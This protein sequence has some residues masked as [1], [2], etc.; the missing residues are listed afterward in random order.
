M[1][2]VSARVP[3]DVESELEA[4]M[5][6]ENVDRSTAIRKLIIEGL[7]DWR[8]ER[9]LDALDAGEV[10]LSRAAEIAELSVWEFSQLATDRNISW[11]ADDDLAA[12]L[13]AL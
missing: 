10:T 1:G 13:D 9:A 11:V 7:D 5:D 6:A 2:T 8:R 4:Y 3:E 12:D